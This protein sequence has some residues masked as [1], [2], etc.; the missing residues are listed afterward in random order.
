MTAPG[1]GHHARASPAASSSRATAKH[2]M[3]DGE[4][5]TGPIEDSVEGE[6]TFHLPAMVG[7][8]EVAGVRLRFE[9]GKVV[10]AERRAR[11]GVPDR[12]CSTPTRARAASASSASAPTTGSTAAPAR[13]CSTRRSAAP[14]T[15][16][17]APAIRSRGGI[18]ESA[19]HTDLVCDLRRGGRIEV[20]GEV[21]QEDGRSSSEIGHASVAKKRT[22]QLLRP[23]RCFEPRRHR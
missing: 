17:S 18:N 5:F 13:S 2:N 6:V 16:R 20:D 19:V 22:P 15:W 4:F 8:R 11:R 7:G 14:S 9:A 10:D 1:H 12:D 21:L 23:R 3:P